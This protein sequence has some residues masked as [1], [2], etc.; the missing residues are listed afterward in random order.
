[1]NGCF[2]LFVRW[3]ARS[4]GL[5]ALFEAAIVMARIASLKAYQS[6]S[7]AMLVMPIVTLALLIPMVLTKSFILSFCLAKT[8]RP[9]T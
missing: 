2:D 5:A 4:R 8:S 3:Q 7:Q 9:R 1:V 6:M